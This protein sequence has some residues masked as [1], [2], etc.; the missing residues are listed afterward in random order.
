MDIANSGLRYS[1][2]VARIFLAHLSADNPIVRRL[3]VAL[4]AAGHDP[5][6]ADGEAGAGE[7]MHPAVERGLRESAVVVVCPSN[8]AAG[9][10]WVE[11]E[12]DI[13]MMQPFRERESG[14][15]PVRLEERC[16]W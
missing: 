8:A 6:L 3:A 13:R 12:P 7:S 1:G 2:A 11:A 5:M 16:P 10:G 14:R 4:R 9:R 15:L